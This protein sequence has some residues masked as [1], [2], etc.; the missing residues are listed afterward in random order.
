MHKVG[1]VW[2]ALPDTTDGIAEACHA[3]AAIFAQ[4]D[5]LA[6]NDEGLLRVSCHEGVFNV[7]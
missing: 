6:N 3:P 4:V 2:L 5:V 1:D 7:L